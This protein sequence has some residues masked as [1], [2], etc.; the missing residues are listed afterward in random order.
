MQRKNVYIAKEK[1][2]TEKDKEATMI[3]N[4][5]DK[6]LVTNI[7]P[8]LPSNSDLSNQCFPFHSDSDYFL[9]L[10]Q[11]LLLLYSHNNSSNSSPEDAPNIPNILQV[12]PSTRADNDNGSAIETNAS[13]ENDERR[14]TRESFSFTDSGLYISGESSSQ[15]AI[16]LLGQTH[17]EEEEEDLIIDVEHC[18]DDPNV[19]VCTKSQSSASINDQQID[20]HDTNHENRSESSQ[21]EVSSFNYQKDQG[22][23]IPQN[24]N[25]AEN[26]G[27]TNEFKGNSENYYNPKKKIFAQWSKYGEI[28]YA[29]EALK[30]IQNIP[31]KENSGVKNINVEEINQYRHKKIRRES[32]EIVKLDNRNRKNQKDSNCDEDFKHE[33]V[34]TTSMFFAKSTVQFIMY[35]SN[36]I[37]FVENSAASVY[38]CP[39][40]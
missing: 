38:E 14:N 11:Q 29:N 12:N 22:H 18:D 25:R 8:Y 21:I 32:S 33:S 31:K 35:E 30:S 20:I 7:I 19:D 13:Y 1:S 5:V 24:R 3:P 37:E 28:G 4:S 26:L 39:M 40:Q 27:N 9:R 16:S 15:D 34:S 6:P 10:Q 36:I 23:C 2:D 17:T